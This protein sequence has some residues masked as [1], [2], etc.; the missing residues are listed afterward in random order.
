MVLMP[1]TVIRMIIA[2][3]A[4]GIT[5]LSGFVVIP[6]LR[7]LKA[8]AHILDIG[9]A[10]HK[11][12]EG[13][14]I[15]G[16]IMFILGTILAGVMG[17]FVCAGD[18]LIVK[19]NVID[20]VIGVVMALLFTGVGFIDDFVKVVK[21]QNEGLTAKQK[22]VLQLLIAAG[23]LLARYIWGDTDTTIWFPFLGEIDFGYFY[24]PLMIMFIYFMVNSVNLT[25]GVD[26]L[27][28][29][30]TLVYTVCFS[31][32]CT[33][34][35]SAEWSVFTFALAG[36]MLGYLVWNLHPAKVMM[37]DTGSMFLG[38]SVV[39][40]GFAMNMEFLIAVAG[41]IYVC[42]SLSVV[43]QVISVKTR[44]GKKLFKMSP[45]HHHFELCK[46][47]EY[48]ICGVFSLVGFLFGVLAIWAAHSSL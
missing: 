7:R 12:K 8:G 41:I 10:W 44:N 33:I 6:Y 9:P 3:V 2:L 30:V 34:F 46:W 20:L 1:S 14:P 16:G 47:G 17:L 32:I 45:I 31:A 42:E 23:Y 26:G 22:T 4:F 11:A 37:G 48:T 39:A 43:L 13:T 19:E 15:M 35:R 18:K 28:G 21:K 38:G 29:C 25:D 36:A 27:C 40:V 24:Y 5:A